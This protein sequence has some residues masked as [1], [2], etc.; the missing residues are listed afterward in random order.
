MIIRRFVAVHA[1]RT[2]KEYFKVIHY[3]TINITVNIFTTMNT[4][5]ITATEALTS[6]IPIV[7]VEFS[8]Q[9]HLEAIPKLGAYNLADVLRGVQS[10]YPEFQPKVFELSSKG[11]VFR[12]LVNTEYLVCDIDDMGVLMPY[13][14]NTIYIDVLPVGSGNIGKIGLGVGL[15][16][17]GGVFGLGFL[18]LSSGAVGLLGASLVFSTLF[19]HPRTDAKERND[20]RSFNFSGTINSTGGGQCLPLAFGNDVTLGSLVASAQIIPQSESV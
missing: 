7:S 18:G 12:A 20:K 19:K 15:A 14:L 6:S 8:E 10:W 9:F 13:Q 11:Y 4:L 3:V 1:T 5:Q 16:L 2:R 17:A